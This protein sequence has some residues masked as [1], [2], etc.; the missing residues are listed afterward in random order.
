MKRIGVLLVICL[1]VLTS[2]TA[3]KREFH[4]LCKKYEE[5]EGIESF[6]LN[7]FGC[8]LGSLFVKCEDQ[9]I[10]KLISKC[11]SC[12]IL[13]CDRKP[14]DEMTRDIKSFMKS[15]KL[16]ELMSVNDGEEQVKIYVEDRKDA[17]RQVFITVLDEEDAV[18]LQIKGDFSREMLRRMMKRPDCSSKKTKM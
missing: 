10:G 5:R 7:G 4:D 16:E 18:F 2:A 3:E 11:S 14:D 1:W 6:G 12:R 13:T 15:N 17:I 9:E 8:F